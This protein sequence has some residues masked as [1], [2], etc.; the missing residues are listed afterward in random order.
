MKVRVCLFLFFF[1]FFSLGKS[2]GQQPHSIQIEMRVGDEVLEL[3]KAYTLAG[4]EGIKWETIRFYISHLEYWNN[5]N[6]VG[7]WNK[8]YHLVDAENPQSL[9]IPNEKNI[10]FDQIR[11]ELGIDSLTNVSGAMGGDLDPTQGMYWAWQTGYINCKIEGTAPN[12]PARK[13]HFQFH[14]GGYLPPNYAMQKVE[15]NFPES[16]KSGK[17][18]WQLDQ[19]FEQI[20][21]HS[22]YEIMRPC[23]AAVELSHTIAQ[24]F[25]ALP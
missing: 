7:E 9:I 19:L 22:Q 12:C 24:Q 11:F 23:E 6:K 10:A 5:G 21:L 8:K 1:S 13:N 17:I 20:D 16:R 15:V 25:K 14:L 2:W 18:G 3:G 4:N